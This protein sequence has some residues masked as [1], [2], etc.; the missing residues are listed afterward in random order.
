MAVLALVAVVGAARFG[1]AFVWDDVPMFVTGDGIYD[2]ASLRIVFV[3][4]SMFVVDHGAFAA[5]SDLDTY[6]PVTMASFILDGMWGGRRPLP[7]HVTGQLLHLLAVGLLYAL[8]R[9]VLSGTARELAWAPAL[10][11]GLH[12]LLVEAHVWIN[13]RSDTLAGVFSLATALVWLGPRG[14]DGTTPLPWWRAWLAAVL[15]LAGALSKEVAVLV[16]LPLVLWRLDAFSL[17]GASIRRR[18]RSTIRDTIPLACAVAVYVAMRIH[19]LRGPRISGG[20]DH[21][22]GAAVRVA[23]MLLD[24]LLHSMVPAGTAVRFLQEEYARIPSAWFWGAWMVVAA[25]VA[26]TLRVRREVPLLPVGVAW[27]AIALA[28]ATLISMLAWYGFDRYLYVPLT[29]LSLGACAGAGALVDA[30]RVGPRA[31]RVLG[32]AFAAYVACLGLLSVRAT[33]DWRSSETWY[34]AMM[35]DYPEESHG[36]GG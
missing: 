33:L 7:F 9:R 26:L 16:L 14:G 19:A 3:R 15:A 4:D 30:G 20:G 11:F 22:R 12:P 5:R 6:R 28:P 34:A 27:F 10:W 18:L 31:R 25:L 1:N 35:R 13:G 36:A 24:G 32:L 17:D 8:G 21:L 29:V 2:P 23:Y